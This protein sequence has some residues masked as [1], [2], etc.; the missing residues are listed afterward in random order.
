M[1]GG[2]G[3]ASS[4]CIKEEHKCDFMKVQYKPRECISFWG[5]N[6]EKIDTDIKSKFKGYWH[7]FTI[8]WS[9]RTWS[10]CSA[11]DMRDLKDAD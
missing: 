10:T 6:G 11:P 9:G 8:H 3:S 7:F 1:G 4:R 5:E 2:E